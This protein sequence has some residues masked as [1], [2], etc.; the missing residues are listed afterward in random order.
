MPEI[1]TKILS[2]LENEIPEQQVNTWLRP[3]QAVEDGA[4]LRLLA[5]NRF[6]VEWVQSHAS[7]RI[8]VLL[9]ELRGASAPLQ[10]EVGSLPAVNGHAHNGH[11]DG[12]ADSPRG[13][14]A[15]KRPAAESAVQIGSRLNPDSTFELFVEGKSNHFAKAAAMQVA[16]NPGKAYNPLF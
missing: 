14:G 12:Q 16:E 15:L 2:R 10:V 13:N 7:S 11:G 8:R 6:A 4:G 9:G 5:P 1:W 3:L